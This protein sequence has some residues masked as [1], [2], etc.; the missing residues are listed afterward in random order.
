MASI[1]SPVVAIKINEW[2]KHIKRFNVKEAHMLREEVR[3]DIDVMEEDEQAVL[4][5][6]LMEF[7]HQLMTDYVQPSK[8][9]LEKSDYLKAVEGQGKKMSAILE[10]YFNFFQ[11]MYEFKNGEFIRAIVFYKRAEKRLEQVGDELERAEFYYKLS[12]VFYHMKQTH[13]SMYYV[14]LSYDTYKAHKSNSLYM[15]REINCLTVMAGNFIDFECREKALPHLLSALE[16]SKAISNKPMIV[17]SLF[18]IGCCYKGLGDFNRALAYFNQVI[19]EGEPIHATELLL[20]YYEL[21]L[22]HLSQKEFIEGERFFKRG[23]EEAKNRKNDL[24]LSLLMVLEILFL[25]TANLSEV[26]SSLEKLENERGYPYMEDLA[27]EAARYYNENGRMDESV[28]MYE[29][30]MYARKQ[31]QRGDCSYEF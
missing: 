28:K 11:G 22:F 17:K 12:E 6:Q 18:N 19:L 14:G 15:I 9:P 30:V 7:R 8:K 31:I 2:Y 5:F 23:L 20:V 21:S 10:Y 4:Y 26:L 1:P 27:L 24:F 29:K 13:V 25:K 16:K 3:K